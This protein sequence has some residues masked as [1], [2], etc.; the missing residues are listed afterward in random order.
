MT[1]N[2]KYYHEQIDKLGNALVYLIE[3]MGSLPKTSLLKLVYIIE[4]KS[5]EKR[6]MPFF[7][8]DFE[9]WKFGPVC[10]NL[11]VEFTEEPTILKEYI[12]KRNT[13]NGYV[14]DKVTNF[15]DD[16]FSDSDIALMD[17]IIKEFSGANCNDLVEYTHRENSLWYNTAK[18]NGVL[19]LLLSE[20]LP[21][22]NIK[23]DFTEL[24]KNEPSK[25][26]FYNEHKEFLSFV[27]SLKQ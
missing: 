20:E 16:E 18:E 26:D 2:N 25:L 6:S 12:K 24:I 1:I 8:L 19:E 23:I 13:R 5:I 22:T 3:Q 10:Q 7:N 17:E 11:Y 9:V 27:S 21:T 4:E 14:F 15:N